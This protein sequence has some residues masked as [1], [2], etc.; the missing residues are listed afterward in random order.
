MNE[1]LTPGDVEAALVEAW[2]LWRRSPGGGRWPFASD[3]PWHLMVRDGNLGDWDARG[4]DGDA[5]P[6]RLRGLTV[7][8]V[9]RRDQ[10]SAWLL[11]APERDRRLVAAVIEQIGKSG[12]RA[13]WMALRGRFPNRQGCA[14]GAD[15]LRMR[16]GRALSTIARVVGA[17]R[18]ETMGADRAH[19][20][21]GAG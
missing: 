12:Q 1:V 6:P 9:A 14:L 5:P 7:A 10:V 21:G 11:L 20:L 18:G 19:C 2:L 13:D 8:E 16:Y 4:I 3:G 17:R 15:G